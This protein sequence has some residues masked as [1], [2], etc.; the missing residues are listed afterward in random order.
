MSEKA[1]V[2]CSDGLQPLNST[3]YRILYWR[4]DDFKYL[5]QDIIKSNAL[6]L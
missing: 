6:P 5:A 3:K 2:K 4:F 1:E